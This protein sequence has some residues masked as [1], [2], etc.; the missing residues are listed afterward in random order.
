MRRLRP[1]A[2]L[3]VSVVSASA[4]ARAG[5]VRVT[6]ANN[7]FNP[8][9]TNINAGDQVAWVWAGSF[10]T[11]TSGDSSTGTPDFISFRTNT[12]SG[13]GATAP[14][15]S[16]KSDG[17][18]TIPYF[19]EVHAPVMAGHVFVGTGVPVSDFRLTEV[20]WNV[21]GGLDLL[22][23]TNHGAVSGNLGRYRI[24]IGAGIVEIPISDIT[25]AAGGHLVVHLHASGTN[26]ATDIFLP[27]AP[28]LP[29]LQGSVTVLMP[30][31]VNPGATADQV[32][33]YLE[34][35][36]AGQPNEAVAAA[37]STWTTGQAVPNVAAGH[38]VELCGFSPRSATAWGEISTP[39]FGSYGSCTTPAGGTTWGRIKSLYR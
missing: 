39:N 28:E 6:V 9:T 25:V 38:S 30:N 2:V 11:V 23:I 13:S 1:L 22:E 5:Q 7:L 33:D 31:T 24:G 15:F 21:P 27:A 12:M 10:H 20:Q 19:C 32:V 8:R 18:A 17:A 4:I 26:T 34:W 14:A 3:L 29:D 36:A 35:G 16:W 37:A